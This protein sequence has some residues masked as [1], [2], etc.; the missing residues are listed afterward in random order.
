MKKLVIYSAILGGYDSQKNHYQID[1]ADYVMFSDQHFSHPTWKVRTVPTL[2]IGPQRTNRFYKLHPHQFFPEYE[3][4]LYIDGNWQMTGDL[5]KVMLEHIGKEVICN[6]CHSNTSKMDS[7]D[8]GEHCIKLG[9]A[10]AVEI[11][12][13]LDLY[14]RAGLPEAF[15]LWGCQFMLRRHI[16]VECIQLMTLWWNEIKASTVRDQ[17]SYPFAHY[18][19]GT[20]PACTPGKRMK[21][22]IRK[23]P[24]AK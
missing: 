23:Y 20:F 15:G 24:H 8:E 2:S 14:R 10:P 5:F 9:K 1:G 21:G 16:A 19:M 7:Y 17:I 3:Y 22:L 4:S 12:A 6:P 13:Q 11:Q 18:L